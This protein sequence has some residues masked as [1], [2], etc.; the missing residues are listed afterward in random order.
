MKK[1]II[2]LLCL[3]SA[4]VSLSC[5]VAFA[6]WVES[7]WVPASEAPAGAE[8]ISRKWTYTVER[9]YD[10]SS[11]DDAGSGAVLQGSDWVQTGSGSVN[12]ASIPAG[13]DTSH[14]L[15]GS[16]NHL[17]FYASSS[18]RSRREVSNTWAG[19]VYWHWMYNCGGANGHSGRAILNQYGRG[20]DNGFWYQYFGA[21]QSTNGSY[22]FDRFYCNSRSIVNYIIPERK[23]WNECQGATRW[24][25][26]DYYCST[27]TDY[28]KVYHYIERNSGET[29]NSGDIPQQATDITEYVR[30]RITLESCPAPRL[31]KASGSTLSPGEKLE[32]SCD[33]PG[34]AI[35]YA[36]ALGDTAPGE[37]EYSVYTEPFEIPKADA[38]Q[39]YAYAR[40]DGM[41]TSDIVRSGYTVASG[42][43]LP[44]VTT[45]AAENVTD[46]SA[47]L[48]AN[49]ESGTELISLSFLYF[50]KNNSRARKTVEAEGGNYVLI[51]GLTPGTEYR[52]QAIAMNEFGQSSGNVLSF[53]TLSR[54]TDEAASIALTPS[55]LI[56]QPG[57]KRQL[58]ATVLPATAVSGIYWRS[59]DPKVASVDQTGV[60]TAAGSGRTRV[61]ATTVSGRLTAYC[62][63]EVA[64]RPDVTGDFDFS[65]LNMIMRSSLYN[66]RS[67][68]DVKY[69]RGGNAVMASAYLARWGGTVSEETDPYPPNGVVTSYNASRETP[70]DYHVQEILYLPWRS[71]SLDNNEIKKAVMSYGAVYTAFR[72]R[73]SDFSEDNTA[74][75]HAREYSNDEGHSV[76]IVGWDDNFPASRFK[77]PP[78][79]DGAFICKNSWG[80]KWGENGY[81]YISYYDVTLGRAACNDINA[82]FYHLQSKEN[83][84][85]IYQYDELGPIARYAFQSGT[86]WYANVF[87]RGGEALT[88]SEVLKAV[89]FYTVSPST[90]YELYLVRDYQ[91][92]ASLEQLGRPIKSGTIDYAGY[93]TITLSEAERLAAGTR[94]AVVIKVTD[95][96]ENAS[97]FVE[98]PIKGFSSRARAG[99]DESYIREADGLWSDLT[100]AASCE[101]T[102]V[103]LKAFTSADPD[104]SLLGGGGACAPDGDETVHT[105]EE[106]M[107]AG[108]SF[109]PEFA[110][111]RDEA[112]LMDGE[113]E[114]TTGMFPPVV[115]PNLSASYNYAEGGRFPARYDLREEGCVTPVRDQGRLGSC[116]SFAAY[117]SLESS[118]LRAATSKYAAVG[119][120]NQATGEKTI[121]LDLDAP[122]LILGVGN[123]V[124]LTATVQPYDSEDVVVWS[125]SGSDVATVS[126]YGIVTAR[127][128]GSAEI[129]ASTEDGSASVSCT[130]FV[131]APEEAAAISL[132][133][134]EESLAAGDVTLIDYAIYPSNARKPNL[135]W[136]SDN[137]A[138]A[139]VDSYGLVTAIGT[140]TANITACVEGS[141]T[142]A[143]S[144]Q[145]KVGGGDVVSRV[146]EENG[147]RVENGSVKGALT[148][149]AENLG[150]E[151]EDCVFILALYTGEG[152]LIDTIQTCRRLEPGQSQPISWNVDTRT[153]MDGVTYS[154]FILREGSQ[155]PLAEKLQGVAAGGQRME[156]KGAE[157]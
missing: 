46:T 145:I 101:N 22:S 25:R 47:V 128:T 153:P 133:S 61:S 58:M 48:Y 44:S 109:N 62:T 156:Q 99:E 123:S 73:N 114:F 82:V 148:I 10:V 66:D 13:F 105:I 122:A 86:G 63:V 112:E 146:L 155:M 139:S 65:E 157:T 134:P 57:E 43:G 5:P 154:V 50:E 30:Y 60:V 135:I 124:Q 8:I 42:Q 9:R 34:A 41:S 45:L 19:Y 131:S 141:G 83:F 33:A 103:C 127:G 142:V 4:V 3:V 107:G 74:Y 89:S 64:S 29:E 137:P 111:R 23:S 77:S 132:Y 36:I 31:S 28:Q 130:I 1:R 151:A 140:G 11:P 72:V 24:F 54:G 84:N 121:A 149:R 7:D 18:D 35:Y 136:E 49:A 144:I 150:E 152:Q 104:A 93:H 98:T 40:K 138:V 117:A 12:Y 76:A 106:L 125:S 67:G 38:F 81:F 21:F 79:G 20:P 100:K 56:V 92:A 75:Y 53:K 108:L 126:P 15:Y 59:E 14:W 39:V 88:E 97:I 143:Q 87:P 71:D 94:F 129:T 32:I 95:S 6:E 17:P 120:L 85:K 78:P 52:F 116:W 51:S 70:A 119:G 115:L 37:Q 27:Y 102:N 69:D 147:L 118:V 113:A 2:A 96:K 90:E 26:F 91:G 68:F 55:Y 110:A 80:D 16:L